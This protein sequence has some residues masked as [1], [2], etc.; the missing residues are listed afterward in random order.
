ME[1]D[2]ISVWSFKSG[3]ESKPKFSLEIRPLNFGRL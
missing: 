2:E 3:A 1:L